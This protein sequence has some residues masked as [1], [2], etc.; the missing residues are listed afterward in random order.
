MGVG[1]S[2][3][4]A[5]V[6]GKGLSMTSR[7]SDCNNQIVKKHVV[8]GGRK[9]TSLLQAGQLMIIRGPNIYLRAELNGLR[10]SLEL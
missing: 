5:S 6:W 2:A 3:S 10:Q 8:D 1:I 4:P 7:A 9:E